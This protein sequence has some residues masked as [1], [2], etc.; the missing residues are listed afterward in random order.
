ML[1]LQS[2]NIIYY[3]CSYFSA[4]NTNFT[5]LI[6][7][8]TPHPASFIEMASDKFQ[9]LEALKFQHFFQPLPCSYVHCVSCSSLQQSNWTQSTSLDQKFKIHHQSFDQSLSTEVRKIQQRCPF[10]IW[11]RTCMFSCFV[12]VCWQLDIAIKPIVLLLSN[13]LLTMNKR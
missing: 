8:C 13:I 11:L 10:S 3:H 7:T 6:G 2:C 4:L 5:D 9:P 1:I 12:I